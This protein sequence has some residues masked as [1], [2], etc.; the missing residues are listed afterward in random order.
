[1]PTCC[2]GYSL[3]SRL[4]VLLRGAL[5]SEIEL[6][7]DKEYIAGRKEGSDIR[8]QAEKGISREHFKLKWMDGHWVL[9]AISRFGEIFSLG[10]KIE[11]TTLEHG[12]NFQVPPYEFQL[13]DVPDS[14]MASSDRGDA[15]FS[16][17]SKTVVGAAPQVPYIKLVNSVNQ[18]T[19]MLRLEV[20]D[21]WV[22]GRDPSCQIV[23]PDQRVSRRQ[24]EIHKVNGIFTILDLGSVNG[25]FLNGSSVSSTDPQPLRSGDAITVLDNTIYFELH[26]PNF[27]IKIGKIDIPSIPF[28]MSEVDD[29][30]PRP[31]HMPTE[32]PEVVDGE[33]QPQLDM[34]GGGPFTG[35]PPQNDQ[36]QFYSFTKSPAAT[37][38]K[39]L[40][41]LSKPM[42]AT[43]IIGILGLAA[44]FGGVFDEPTAPVPVTNEGDAYTKLSPRKQ[45]EIKELYS[46]ADQMLAQQK[47][48][49]ALEKIRKIHEELPNGFKESRAMQ[50]QAEQSLLTI[51]QQQEDEKRIREEEEQRKTFV[52]VAARCEKLISPSVDMDKLKECLIPIATIDPS[53]ADYIRLTSTAE[54]LIMDRKLKEAEQ[55]TYEEQ[56]EQLQKLF[57]KAEKIQ[58]EGYA[59]KAIKHYKIVKD[60]Q[61]ADPKNLKRKAKS[62]IE[63][64]EKKIEEKTQKSMAQAETLFQEGKLKESVLSL[65]EA[66]VYD[67]TNQKIKDKIDSYTTEL[68]RQTIVF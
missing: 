7:P 15:N 52:E 18:V 33:N 58:N 57:A 8:L 5:I 11:E 44:Y 41:N 34:D 61:L 47:F 62:R 46:L 3:M 64:I 38:K 29:E 23:I 43:L 35:V 24:F 1:M 26:D 37:L 2:R 36:N 6:N 4:K 67:P 42:L 65:R 63:F 19:E 51:I 49:L 16:E 13:L 39:G 59:F 14:D 9:Q 25:T 28:E 53:N 45:E 50:V 12:Q 21:L 54:K 31:M 68:R 60:A 10:Q 20:G 56:V 22:A 48:D 17:V 66:L 30:V 40:A 32:I 27:K 55:Q